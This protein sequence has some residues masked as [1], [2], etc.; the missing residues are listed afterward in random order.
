M[1]R[2]ASH[3]IFIHHRG[4]SKFRRECVASQRVAGPLPTGDG[5][6]SS[7]PGPGGGGYTVM[8]G[9]MLTKEE[10]TNSPTTH[11]HTD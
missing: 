4:Y 9:L 2:R 11:C 1:H 6:V 7:P 5:R 8:T 10:S 3:A